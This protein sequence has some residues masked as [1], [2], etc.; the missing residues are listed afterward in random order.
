MKTFKQ[1]VEAN[2]L[3]SLKGHRKA[4]DF[5]QFEIDNPFLQ[6]LE[7]N[8]ENDEFDPKSKKPA[9]S[10]LEIKGEVFQQLGSVEVES[11]GAK[12]NSLLSL[13]LSMNKIGRIDAS[14]THSCPHLLHLSLS[15]NLL[16]SIHSQM[17]TAPA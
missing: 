15:D 8:A 9:Q 4:E 7:L 11:L 14:I 2:S 13:N 3:P 10:E 17:F 5:S 16:K 6:A 12:F 1:Y